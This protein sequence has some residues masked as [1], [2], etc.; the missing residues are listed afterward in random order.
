MVTFALER[1]PVE[2][3]IWVINSELTV[4]QASYAK[5]CSNAGDLSG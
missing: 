3:E 2:A 4:K 1:M 5:N